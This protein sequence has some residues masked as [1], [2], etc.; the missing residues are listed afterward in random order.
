MTT[1]TS[2]PLSTLLE[3]LFVDAAASEADLRRQLGNLSPEE[4]AARVRSMT[5]YVSYYTRAK[6]IYLAV[7][8]ETAV[9]LYMLARNARARSIVEFGTS[10]GISTLHLAAALKDNGGG[11]LIGSEFEPSKVVRAR[12]RIL[13]PRGFLTLWKFVR[14]THWKRWHAIFPRASTW[15]Y[16]TARSPFIRVCWRCS[17]RAYELARSYWRIMPICVRSI[18]QKSARRV[19]GTCPCPSRRMSS[20]R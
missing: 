1:L 9:L 14:A 7:S 16:S 8:R 6:D 19:A 20:C 10:F 15:C 11:R 17:S 12:E 13:P 2:P 3:R 18:W 5:D 4:R